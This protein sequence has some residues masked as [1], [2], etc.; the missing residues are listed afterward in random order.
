MIVL[1]NEVETSALER[2]RLSGSIEML[3]ETVEELRSERDDAR[4]ELRVSGAQWT[5]IVDNATRLEGAMWSEI[6]VLRLREKGAAPRGELCSACGDSSARLMEANEGLR[7][8]VQALE[9]ALERIKW[10]GRKMGDLVETLGQLGRE[11]DQEVA[12]AVGRLRG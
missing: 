1:E 6:G 11:I 2:E 5:R 9:A 3:E 7:K 12:V 8:R 4:V 10:G